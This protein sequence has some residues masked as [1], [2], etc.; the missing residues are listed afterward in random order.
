MTYQ[1]DDVGN[2]IRTVDAKG[3][4]IEYTYDF[5]ERLKTE[6]YLSQSGDANDPVDIIY[7]YDKPSRNIDFGDGT[8]GTATFTAGRLAS[9]VDLSGEEHISYDAL[10]NS[11]W[12][13]KKILDPKTGVLVP[14]KT[15]FDYDLLGRVTG[16]Y[17]PDNDHVEYTYNSGSLVET[18]GGGPGG[19]V[20]LSNVDY[21]PASLFKSVSF[22]NGVVTSYDYDNRNRLN[23][24]ITAAADHTELINFAYQY[25]PV[26]NIKSIVDNRSYSYVPKT[27]PRRNTQVFQYDDLYRLTQVRFAR[28]DDLQANIGRIDYAYDAIGNMLSKT[29]ADANQPGHID[30]DKHVNLGAM[31][32]SGGTSGRIGRNPG[33][34]PGPHALTSTEN[35]AVYEYDDNGN[36]TNIDG[37][38]CTWDFEDRLVRYRKDDIDARYAYDYTGRRITKLVTKRGLTTQTLYPNRAFEIRPNQAPTKFVFNGSKRVARVKGALD[39]N[40]ERIQRIWL[41]EGKN[42]VCLAVRSSQNIGQVFGADCSAYTWDGLTY[43]PRLLSETLDVGEAV[44]IDVPTSRVASAVGVYDSQMSEKEVSAGRSL[45]GWPRLEP[46]VPALHLYGQ[47]DLNA[48][49]PF[50]GSWLHRYPALPEFVSN[51]PSELPAGTGLWCSTASSATITSAPTQSH[52]VLFY[53]TDHLGSSS[54]ITDVNGVVVQETANYPFGHPRNDLPADPNNPF[55]ADYKFTGKEQDKESGLQYFGARY[56]LAHTGSF[57]SVDPLTLKPVQKYIVTPDFAHPYAYGR[58][59]PIT[60][61]DPDGR[62]VLFFGGSIAAT[63]ARWTGQAS[64]G[65]Y[66]AWGKNQKFDIGAYGALGGGAVL[67]PAAS[68]SARVELGVNP[69]TVQDFK[70]RDIVLSGGVGVGPPIVPLGVEGGVAVSGNN[71]D[72]GKMTYS[73]SGGVS[74]GKSLVGVFSPVTPVASVG[75]L[76]TSVRSFLGRRYEKTPNWEET[77]QRLNT[78]FKSLDTLGKGLVNKMSGLLP[79]RSRRDRRAERAERQRIQK[80]ELKRAEYDTEYDDGLDV[81]VANRSG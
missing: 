22:G 63:I 41:N 75:A 20:I 43:N 71:L 65:L 37:A 15:A 79:A 56:Y 59:G 67:D 9:V 4:V 28:R 25:D 5:A 39:P 17:Y 14:Y 6:N 44:W 34:L 45:Q 11:K 35:G 74:A 64:G 61:L 60:Y 51:M 29:S 73:I 24:L 3:Q 32:Y 53:H 27:S 48:F 13:V 80:P 26:S 52:D 40:R 76:R 70:S 81:W 55:R 58:H 77:L 72:P 30:D 78:T 62:I 54:V 57:V 2:L 21:G 36:V 16:V 18:V 8:I 50:S 38:L 19:R 46:F 47:A 42:L 66:I 31:N 49:D 7:S 10:G 23:Y 68:V 1:Y 33:D 12:V 69:G